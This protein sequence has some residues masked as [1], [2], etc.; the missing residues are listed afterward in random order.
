MYWSL[1]LV[2]V[3][4]HQEDQDEG[5]DPEDEAGEGDH[6]R[7]DDL[8]DPDDGG[9]DR[10]GLDRV[11]GEVGVE[12]LEPGDGGEVPAGEESVQSRNVLE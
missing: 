2:S 11:G 7:G 6:D 5:R 4:L 8:L 1:R 9:D 12:R 3:V 10:V